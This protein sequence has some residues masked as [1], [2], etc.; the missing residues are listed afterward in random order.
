MT[1]G[2]ADATSGP[3]RRRASLRP[4]RSA[5]G[6]SS[7]VSGIVEG[8]ESALGEV[9]VRA[10]VCGAGLLF[11]TTRDGGAIGVHLYQGDTRSSSFAS[12]E[13]D[14]EAVI[15]AVHD[16]LMPKKGPGPP[17]WGQ[18]SENG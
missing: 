18:A 3:G 2:W 9:L 6:G 10:L 16:R 7:R 4:I 8:K 5:D 1:R 15:Q 11:T 17:K 12:S 14:L 13:E